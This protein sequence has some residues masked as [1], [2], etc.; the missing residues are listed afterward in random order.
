MGWGTGV[1]VY[2]GTSEA[3]E[4]RD[5]PIM[6]GEE[7]IGIEAKKRLV[8]VARAEWRGMTQTAAGSRTATAGYTITARERVDDSGQW[9]VSEEMKTEGAWEADT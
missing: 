6:A 4:K 7:V 9:R 2:L 5:F 1:R 8:T 3:V